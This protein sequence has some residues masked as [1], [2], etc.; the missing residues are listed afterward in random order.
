M[1]GEE[2]AKE[3]L[4]TASRHYTMIHP[5]VEGTPANGHLGA[6]WGLFEKLH[7]ELKTSNDRIYEL[8]APIRKIEEHV[9]KVNKRMEEEKDGT[10]KSA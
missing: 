3:V 10:E 2:E 9:E 5:Y 4:E 1:L 8:E 6:L 7:G